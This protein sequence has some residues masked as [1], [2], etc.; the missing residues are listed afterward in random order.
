MYSSQA[1]IVGFAED[2]VVTDE[3]RAGA[4]DFN[5]QGIDPL[6]AKCA[7]D[8]QLSLITTCKVTAPEIMQST[9]SPSAAWWELLQRYHACGLK[10]KSKLMREFNSLKMEMG[11]DP[12]KFTMRVD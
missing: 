8:A 11:E 5:S 3:I 2:L 7:S 10:E 6:R 9:D 12:K 1:K 4:E